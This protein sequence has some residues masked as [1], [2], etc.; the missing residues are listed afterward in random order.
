MVLSELHEASCLSIRPQQIPPG[1]CVRVGD[2]LTI[3]RGERSAVRQS[4]TDAIWYEKINSQAAG[5]RQLMI[6]HVDTYKRR[7]LALYCMYTM[8]WMAQAPISHPT[9]T[10]GVCVPVKLCLHRFSAKKAKKRQAWLFLELGLPGDH[11]GNARAMLRIIECNNSEFSEYH[12]LI[13]SIFGKKGLSF[14]R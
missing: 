11:W 10:S 7:S 3:P 1:I 13:Y 9:V 8:N 5:L 6:L 12:S 14:C 4:E 2:S